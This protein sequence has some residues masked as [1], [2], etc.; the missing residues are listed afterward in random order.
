MQAEKMPELIC[1]KC[2][3]KNP[4]AYFAPAAGRCVCESCARKAGFVDPK[5][6]TLKPGVEL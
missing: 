6:G 4:F 1:R 3:T 5:T 2:G